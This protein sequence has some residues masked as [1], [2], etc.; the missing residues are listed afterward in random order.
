[1]KVKAKGSARLF[2]S[3]LLEMGTRTN[4]LAVLSIYIPLCTVLIWYF[5][6]TAHPTTLLLIGLFFGGVFI[7]TF[8]EYIL[9]RYIFHFVNEKKWSQRFHYLIHGV[10][11][12]YPKDKKR[13]VMPPMASMLIA[14]IFFLGFHL[15][16]GN[17]V[18]VFFSGFI[19]GYI[20]YDMI[21]YSLHAF[22]PAKNFAK[23]YWEYHNIHHFRYPDMAYG[24]SSPL[25]DFIFGTYPPRVVNNPSEANSIG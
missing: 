7:W 18:Y 8:F 13:L 17:Y 25:W 14:A 20:I 10:H 24:V 15:I 3:D 6:Y 11:H 1:M 22:R 4:P 21:H 9:H 16:L 23:F 19:T 5:Y 12:E 2:K